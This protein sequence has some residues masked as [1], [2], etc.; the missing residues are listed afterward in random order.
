MRDCDV[1]AYRLPDRRA[2]DGVR[3]VR[4]TPRGVRIDRT[5]CGIKMRVCVPIEAYQAI[6][7]TRPDQRSCRLTLAHADPDLSVR[8]EEANA[9]D[10]WQD[11]SGLVAA[12]VGIA[13]TT[14]AP[15]RRSMT[16]VKRRPRILLRR[17]P[18]RACK[19]LKILHA[20]RELFSWE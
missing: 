17:R 20:A 12:L 15:R 10:A 1:T 16:L 7:L 13:R 3:T 11:W 8:L 6:L 14:P 9:E 4:L 19:P 5:V 18:G 2:D